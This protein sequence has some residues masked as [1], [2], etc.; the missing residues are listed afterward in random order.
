[1]K[2]MGKNQSRGYRNMFG[3][4]L[5]KREEWEDAEEEWKIIK[6]VVLTLENVNTEKRRLYEL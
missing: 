1:M 4:K 5:S 6:K 2:E 3:T